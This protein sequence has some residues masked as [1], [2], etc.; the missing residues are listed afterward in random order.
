M[1][2]QATEDIR[3]VLCNFIVVLKDHFTRLSYCKPIPRKQPIFV[4]EVLCCIFGLIG[5]PKLLH[6]DNGNEFTSQELIEAIKDLDED[7][8]SV[9]GRPRKPNDQ[10]SVKIRNKMVKS[11]LSDVQD[12]QRRKGK[13][14]NWTTLMEHLMGCLNSHELRGANDTSAYETVFGV[15]YHENLLCHIDEMRRCTTLEQRVRINPDPRFEASLREEF[16]L[17]GDDPVVNVDTGI[18]DA[19]M[20]DFPADGEEDKQD[21]EQLRL[22]TTDAKGDPPV[23]GDKEGRTPLPQIQLEVAATGDST[24][25]QEVPPAPSLK[26]R[27]Q[28]LDNEGCIYRP[29]TCDVC[30]FKHNEV[31]LL[32]AKAQYDR[33]ILV[34]DQWWETAYITSFAA[35]V[36][37]S[38]HHG[39]LLFV[40]CQEEKRKVEQDLMEPL[41][42]K[43][44]KVLSVLYTGRSDIDGHYA[45]MEID[46]K[47]RR[48]SIS[49]G[50]SLPLRTW[51][52]HIV[53]VLQ[54]TTLVPLDASIRFMEESKLYLLV[55]GVPEWSVESTQLVPQKDGNNCG[56]IACLKVWKTFLPWEIAPDL[57]RPAEYRPT[58]VKKFHDLVKRC[59]KEINWDPS[60]NLISKATK[61][62]GGPKT[63]SLVE[64]TRKLRESQEVAI[65]DEVTGDNQM[66]CYPTTT[67]PGK[68]KPVLGRWREDGTGGEPRATTSNGNG[69]GKTMEDEIEEKP[70]R[71]I[72]D[73][74]IRNERRRVACVKRKKS[75][76]IQADKMVRLRGKTLSHV[77]EGTLVSMKMDPRDAKK[78]RGLLGI[79]YD[80]S[81]NRAGGIKVATQC[82]IITKKNEKN[83]YFVPSDRYAV[84]K[85]QDVALTP[86]LERVRKEIMVGKFDRKTPKKVSMPKAYKL[87]EGVNVVIKRGCG[88]KGQR[89]THFCGCVKSK[90]KCTSKCNCEGNCCNGSPAVVKLT[91][92]AV[93]TETST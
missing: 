34:K 43:V 31:M 40:H 74:E 45:V 10:G 8:L 13:T 47:N 17:D 57:L 68:N 37:H 42:D 46:R 69:G 41:D 76:I 55:D 29:L 24:G 84:A 85:I 75:Q 23:D 79:V 88:C 22:A 33:K 49:D 73:V 80:T 28:S 93:P 9:F 2:D 25:L 59:R 63:P 53:N 26:R 90:K 6:S 64:G 32:I 11:V 39:D 1:Q 78:A 12:E 35:M 38:A 51:D 4:A 72:T 36:A 65:V 7:I 21:E 18:D 19:L 67:S 44:Q 60:A 91:K 30:T 70:A 83:E 61:R 92:G 89:C 71:P 16:Y 54:R 5:A 56:P 81:G 87:V 15:P 62:E 20:Q 77:T 48:I 50:M 58:L 3:G 27:C 66:N 14:T 52:C 86:G 82:G